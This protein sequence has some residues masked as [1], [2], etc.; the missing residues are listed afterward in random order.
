MTTE[1]QRQEVHAE[2]AYLD[3]ARADL[4][5]MREAVMR[6]KPGAGDGVSTE[7][8]KLALARRLRSLQDDPELPLFFGRI[9]ASEPAETYYIGRRHVHDPHGD[10]V[11]V[12]WRAN[13]SRPFYLAT[14]RHPLSVRRRRRFGFHAGAITAIEDEL[15][16]LGQ[17]VEGISEL[18][19]AEVE[20][21]RTG[22]MRDIVATIQPDQDEIV[23]AAL[24]EV[25]CVQ[26]G[27]GTGKT[28]VGLH[29]AAYLLYAHAEKLRRSG[30]LIIGPN[31]AFIRYISQVLPALGEFDVEQRPLRE[32][33]GS[34]I[35]VR[36]TEDPAATLK[37]DARMAVVIDRHIL[38]HLVPIEE[39]LTADV[40]LTRVRLQ[41]A[42]L[43]RIRRGV[44]QRSLPYAAGR[45]LFRD[46]VIDELVRQVERVHT[47]VI[48]GDVTRALRATDAARAL[49]SAW[50][51]LHPAT[52]VIELLTDRRAMAAAAD[53]VLAG[54]EQDRLMWDRKA[55]RATASWSPA[56]LV[57]VD[58]AAG[59]IK[60][61]ESYGHVVVDEAQDLSG[62]ELRAIA[63]R[64]RGSLTLLGDLAQAVTPWAPRSW[65]EV[66]RH[67][68]V[69]APRFELLTR[70]FRIPGSVLEMAN[71][72]LPW[73]A[74][75][76]PIPVPVR[77][78]A[79]ALSVQTV[80]CGRLPE[81]IAAATVMAAAW[82]G[83][84]G[85]IVPSNLV[86]ATGRAL[87][88]RALGWTGVDG[89]GGDTR[90]T[91]L[92]AAE[93]KGLEFDALVVGEPASIVAEHPATG[94]NLLYVALTRA[95]MHLT[96][97]HAEPLP[98][99]LTVRLPS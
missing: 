51:A 95:V 67:L 61:P 20:R 21:P 19:E 64:S 9:D 87:T 35:R 80:E 40:N 42:A 46:C 34:A 90:I 97:V 14:P 58:E 48:R 33:L 93:S 17:G 31:D 52:A 54:A 98:S 32:I 22:P 41:P 83:S 65:D 74:P 29:R 37:H 68:D 30:V 77:D 45:K 16:G 84:T 23:R 85:V 39:A 47:S 28:A 5:A 60:R 94:L 79:D 2:Q 50:P 70:A 63:R 18:V 76:V 88:D 26:G 91:V 27:P 15:V 1:V 81:A 49:E 99:E 4:A 25:V 66:L 69:R 12:D 72:L 36:R 86:E 59:R 92:T 8:L 89:I 71:R 53:G 7:Y 10:P 96:V 55:S 44:V 82:P 75:T 13:V 57:L 43:D 11:V 3:A 56:D 78:S 24:A 38:G 62:M 6:L 73:I